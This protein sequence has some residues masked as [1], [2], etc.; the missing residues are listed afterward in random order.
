MTEIE[1]EQAQQQKQKQTERQKLMCYWGRKF[2]DY[3]SEQPHGSGPGS[4]GSNPVN[5]LE[6]F[7]S[8]VTTKINDFRILIAGEVDCMKKVCQRGLLGILLVSSEDGS[9]YLGVS[10]ET[11]WKLYRT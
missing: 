6:A 7:C 9:D 10:R 3:C 11:A 1:T 5:N 4:R 2:E 8:V